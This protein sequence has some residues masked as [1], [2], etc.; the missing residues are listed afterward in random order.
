MLLI[1]LYPLTRIASQSDLSPQAGRG[2][3][4]R[5][6]PEEARSAVSK[7]EGP[8]LTIDLTRTAHGLLLRSV[9]DRPRQRG[10]AVPGRVGAVDHLRRDADREFRPWRVL[11]ARRLCCVHADRAVLRRARLL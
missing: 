8:A 6:H 5:P 3:A 7:D 4:E 11:H 9:P 1:D 10:V 2:K